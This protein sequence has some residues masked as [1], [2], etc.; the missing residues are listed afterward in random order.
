MESSQSSTACLERTLRILVVDDHQLVRD[1]VCGLLAREPEFDVID[2]ATNAGEAISKAIE[3]RPD[4]ILMDIDMPGIGCF[5][6]VQIIRSRVPQAKVILLTGHDHDEYLEQ[7]IRSKAN[8]YVMKHD[9][10]NAL[11]EAVRN[12]AADRVHFSPLVLDRIQIKETEIALERPRRSDLEKLTP[13]ERELLRILAKG[14]SLKEAA[15]V[16]GIS[17]K[18]ADNQKTSLM[19]K[20]DIHNRVELARFAIREGMVAP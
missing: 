12:V 14:L 17:P 1:G 5:D 6:A 4:I 15:A 16:L 8:G 19:A 11:V 7:A 9:G 13:R 18:T 2:S 3:S 10:V 20:L